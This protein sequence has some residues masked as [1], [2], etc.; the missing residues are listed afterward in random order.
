MRG[1]DVDRRNA[2]ERLYGTPVI[3]GGR[4]AKASLRRFA[5]ILSVVVA[6]LAGLTLL[7]GLILD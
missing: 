6:I 5:L 3:L 2:I 7:F 4:G 1:K